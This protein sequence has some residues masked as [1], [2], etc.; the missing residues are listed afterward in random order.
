VAKCV[1]LRGP[2]GHFLAILPATDRIDLH[3]LSDAE[4]GPVRLAADGDIADVFRDCEWGVVSPF[5]SFYG[6][7]TY[8]DEQVD[9]ATEVVFECEARG[10]AIRMRVRDFERLEHPRRIRFAVPIRHARLGRV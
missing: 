2:R 4:D 10:V 7:P 1:L 5:G 9:S 8:V 3:R 6:L